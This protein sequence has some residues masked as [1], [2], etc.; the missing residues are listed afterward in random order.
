MNVP[1]LDLKAQYAT[2]KNEIQAAVSEVME[3]TAFA[4]GPY[5]AGFE[6]KFAGF[7]GCKHAIGVGNGTDA[8]WLSL[9][10]LGIGPGDEVITVPN[11]FIATAEAI[12][13]C[14]AKPVFVDVEEETF[15]M[16]PALLESAITTKTKAVIP[17]HL[18]GQTADMDPI[19]AIARAHGLYVIED[20]CQA[21]GAQYKGRNAGTMGDTGCFSFYP[22]KN[23]G[24]YGEAGAVVTNDDAVAEKIRMFRD[25]GQSKKYYHGVIGWNARMDGIQGAILNVKLKYLAGWNESRRAHAREYTKLLSPVHDVITPY[26]ADYAKHIYHIYAIRTGQRNQLLTVLAERGISCGIHYPVPIHLQ[27]AYR[28]L[29][30]KAGSYPVAEK[31][32]DELL[33]LPMFPELTTEQIA[34][35]AGTLTLILKP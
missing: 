30:L 27:D 8:L 25:H 11:T 7:C 35:I 16:N 14:G 10:A 15:N 17:V 33:S 23:L 31:C 1:F 28:F 29:G 26:E 9:L 22:G 5:V 21:H 19:L 12:T 24:A 6:K 13:Y 20:A 3:N 4:G 34:Y 2:I 18:F 32:A